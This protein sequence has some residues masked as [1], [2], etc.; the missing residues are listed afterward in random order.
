MIDNDSAKDSLDL[1][2]KLEHRERQI[3]AIRAITSALFSQP[4]VDDMV[5]E[6]LRVAIE[7]LE[8]E[9]GSVQLHDAATNR[10]VFRHV[11]DP[12][13]P[14][15]AGESYPVAQGIGGQVF[16]TG[17]PQLTQRVPEHAAF[18]RAIDEKTGFHTESML[19]VAL[20]RFDGDPFGVMQI[21]NGRRAFDERDLEVLEVL[22]AQA[23][24]AI[25]SAHLVE[26]ARKAEIANLIGDISHDIKNMLTPIKSGVLTLEPL[27]DE[28]CAGLATVSDQCPQSEPWGNKIYEL[29]SLVRDDYGWILAAILETT[30]K[31]Q[32]RTKVIADVVKGESAPLFFEETNVNEIVEA[33]LR[34]LRLVAQT[35][36][37]TLRQELDPE[38]P[39]AQLDR[40]Q[41]YNALY[42]LVNNAI[43]E[44]P[45]GGN[46]TIRTSAPEP[47]QPFLLIEVEDTGRGIPEPIRSRLFTDAAISSK[48]GGTGLGTRIV[49][50]VVRRHQGNV[51]VDSEE[52]KGSKFSIRLPLQQSV[53]DNTP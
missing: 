41:I 36:H 26:Q 25:E 30:D 50:D 13:A 19:T 38:L 44:T 24:T 39:R 5:R 48:P 53:S 27:L 35:A 17:I 42:N 3:D 45:A 22:S 43:P 2:G 6:T 12:S 8:G 16:A 51:T 4:S 9:A 1:R 46:I 32:D 20:K 23:A 7:V 47:A 31:L 52:G 14:A 18:N 40:Q 10:L 33:V 29:L 15:L 21:L 37:I 28:L 34:D 11:I 49:A